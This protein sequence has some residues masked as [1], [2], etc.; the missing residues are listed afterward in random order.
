[1]SS[2]RAKSGWVMVWVMGD[3]DLVWSLFGWESA[4]FS[5]DDANNSRLGLLSWFEILD[6]PSNHVCIASRCL[7]R[8]GPGT[9][10]GMCR[11][12][13]AIPPCS[14]VV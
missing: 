7:E 6:G 4:V 1:M 8:F 11:V 14:P 3:T 12:G 9:G 10:A 2:P 13:H 5:G